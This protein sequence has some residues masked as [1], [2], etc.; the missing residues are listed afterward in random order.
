V[1]RPRSVPTPEPVEI[2]EVAQA[3]R[4]RSLSIWC[5]LHI[6]GE[7][8]QLVHSGSLSDRLAHLEAEIDKNGI[9]VQADRHLASLERGAE[10]TRQH[11]AA[12][13][14]QGYGPA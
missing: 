5:Q 10:R 2:D 11:V 4:Y 3:A 14:Q 13:K 7:G 8:V 1:S 9:R 12:L 6:A